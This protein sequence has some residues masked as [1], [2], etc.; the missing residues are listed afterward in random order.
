MKRYAIYRTSAAPLSRS[1]GSIALA[2]AL[3]A[4]AAVRFDVFA[5][6]N[7]VLSL[8]FVALIG[9]LAVLCALFAVARIW[10]RGGPGLGSAL[11]GGFLGL[12]GV[13]L[14]T[15]VFGLQILHPHFPDISTDPDDPP[16]IPVVSSAEEQPVLVWMEDAFRAVDRLRVG[17]GVRDVENGASLQAV[18]YPD[19]VP[20]RY[21]IPP[22]QLHIAVKEAVGDLGWTVSGE[23]PP[24]ML[25]TPSELTAQDTSLVLAFKHD[26]AVRIK[27][28]SV[29]S[30]LDARVRAQNAIREFSGSADRIRS[31]FARIDGVLLET[32]GDLA[33]LAV[34]E[35]DFEEDLPVETFES[36]RETVPVPGFKPYF[37][38][39]DGL[40]ENE[41]ELDG[42]EG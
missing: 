8:L 30:L 36:D 16:F 39:G 5:F 31:L 19:I 10:R 33:R 3:V 27:P 7:F 18:L 28:D 11:L 2:L 25:D 9:A 41:F 15:A 17:D 42:L 35:E 14:P 22:G 21:R 23:L 6:Q 37:E 24:D 20:R 12:I 29:G 26:I 38:G 34:D 4:V 1:L 13:S 32:Y 40:S